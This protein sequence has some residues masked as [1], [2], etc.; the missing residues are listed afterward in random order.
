MTKEDESNT[1]T[2]TVDEANFIHT[3]EV[4]TEEDTDDNKENENCAQVEQQVTVNSNRNAAEIL[5]E[6]EELRPLE[7]DLT[8]RCRKV[9]YQG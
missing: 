1:T 8:L 5:A 9:V 7:K 6:T 2:I 4:L 3:E